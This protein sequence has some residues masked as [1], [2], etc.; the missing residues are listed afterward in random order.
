MVELCHDD[1][2]FHARVRDVGQ[3]KAGFDDHLGFSFSG[4]DVAVRVVVGI[5]M[6]AAVLW[7]D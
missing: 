3:I 7:M 6:I 1:A 2:G 5:E 4:D